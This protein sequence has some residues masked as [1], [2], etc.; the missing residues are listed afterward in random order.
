MIRSLVVALLVA[1]SPAA[2]AELYKCVDAKG[3][4]QYSDKPLPGCK[5]ERITRAPN[6]ALSEK[7]GALDERGRRVLEQQAH[8]SQ[9][10]QQ[11]KSGD[12]SDAVRET[13]RG[14]Y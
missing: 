2:F 14:C 5:S 3:K 10:Q 6:V 1:A 13:L 7:R 11:L 12:R 4:T 9:A 8:C